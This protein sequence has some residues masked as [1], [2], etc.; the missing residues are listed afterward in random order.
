MPL[1]IHHLRFRLAYDGQPAFEALPGSGL[2]AAVLEP[3]SRLV[4]AGCPPGGATCAYTR[5]PDGGGLA[6]RISRPPVS[7]GDEA[8]EVLAVH[9]PEGAVPGG[10]SP[11]DALPDEVWPLP[12]ADG[13]A[14][15]SAWLEPSSGFDDSRL[16]RFAQ[17][18]ESLLS[19]L[20]ADLRALF[21]PKAGP[22]ILIG[23]QAGP[24]RTWIA[25]LAK[26]LP[27]RYA[28][29]LTFTTAAVH[30][31]L[32]VQQIVGLAPDAEFAYS[33]DELVFTYRVRGTG[34]NRRSG[35]ATDPW[36]EVAA[37]M[38]LAG[39]PELLRDAWIDAAEPFDAGCL[40]VIALR[41]RVELDPD[42]RL[43][44]MQWL[45]SAV[46]T[47]MIGQP[48]FNTLAET[49]GWVA[50]LT[51]EGAMPAAPGMDAAIKRAFLALCRR[52]ASD[53]IDA[54]ATQV[55]RWAL[56]A[57]L[58]DCAAVRT[59][60]IA[61]LK[62]RANPTA[63]PELPDEWR[64]RLAA[65]FSARIEAQFDPALA[66][67]RE[68]IAGAIVLAKSLGVNWSGRAEGLAPVFVRELFDA[69]G[70]HAAALSLIDRVADDR[71]T[72]AVLRQLDE[73][74]GRG[75]VDQGAALARGGPGGG[76][77]RKRRI[78]DATPLL[79]LV[80]LASE[81][82]NAQ[83]SGV[84]RFEALWKQSGKPDDVQ[85][86]RTL[87]DLSLPHQGPQALT[88]A[89]VRFLVKLLPPAALS[90]S[91]IG[92][93][94]V[95]SLTHYAARLRVTDLP[96]VAELGEA[97]RRS[98]L[99]LDSVHETVIDLV[100]EVRRVRAT[101]RLALPETVD[102]IERLLARISGAD[103]LREVSL[104]TLAEHYYAAE[105]ERL[106]DDLARRTLTESFGGDLLRKYHDIH[107]DARYRRQLLDYFAAG[108]DE[109]L[110]DRF[111]LWYELAASTDPSAH[112]I[113]VWFLKE[114]IDAA[115]YRLN[116]KRAKNVQKLLNKSPNKRIV[117]TWVNYCVNHKLLE[118][119]PHRQQQQSQQTQSAPQQPGGPPSAP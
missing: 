84:Q 1:P 14:L 3:L 108:N 61:D 57:A 6:Y 69:A 42:S 112:T 110:A 70:D 40:A 89:E 58:A 34:E 8:Y 104:Q 54:L 56:Q 91:G 109:Y 87:W 48:E 59:N 71:L 29:A 41:E 92:A 46:N 60:P 7:A 99:Q 72:Q 18:H 30:P 23:D 51:A 82:P 117:D 100:A 81:Q 20:L 79:Q 76:W 19:S 55:G 95:D 105:G 15:R 66:T 52:A 22:Q 101:K 38:W 43:I 73:A 25:L 113:G 9:V 39:R 102:H 33:R 47:A 74:I 17:A 65:E 44:A 36:A 28:R 103:G 21:A 31:Y 93:H 80:C 114:L 37:A 86:L 27:E 50:T 11:V 67:T 106:T 77:L 85:R 78:T 94:A 13:G 53:R 98:R 5:L 115:L 97:L 16:V 90:A 83:L 2:D 119:D 118:P 111:T 116:A 63:E 32:A 35:R 12:P 88:A 45:G 62:V 4:G 26:S 107:T 24:A 49:A 64:N 10:F 96:E 68:H 75:D